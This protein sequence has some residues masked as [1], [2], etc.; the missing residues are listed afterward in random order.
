M[1]EKRIKFKNDFDTVA[2]F[3]PKLSRHTLLRILQQSKNIVN[4]T[5][6]FY[7]FRLCKYMP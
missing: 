1:S 3:I 2:N 6:T 4:L 5:A 7:S